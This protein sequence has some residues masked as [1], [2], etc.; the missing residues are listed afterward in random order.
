MNSATFLEMHDRCARMP[1]LSQSWE[2]RL[3]SPMAALY[4]A[5]EAGLSYDGHEDAGQFSGDTL[6]GLAVD[7]GLDTTQADLFGLANHLSAMADLITWLM[8]K[9]GP[10]HRPEN[11]KVGKEPWESSVFLNEAGT[12]LKRIV[13][14][15]HWSDEREISE[16]HSW[17]SVGECAAYG[18]PMDQTILLIGSNRSGRRHG[19]FS[20][21]WTHPVSKQLRMRK[22]NGTGFD[23]S[24]S[25]VFREEWEGSRDGWLDT[26]TDDGILEDAI[27]HVE[28]DVHPESKKIVKLAEKKLAQI[29]E[30]MECPPPSPSQCDGISPCPYR[31]ACWS[32]QT[33]SIQLGY[34][35]IGDTHP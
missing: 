1:F 8:T 3:L 32:F 28:V 23:G 14:V 35:R 16:S 26:M 18:M 6:M 15:D 24:W 21:A 9:D 29:R 7:R 31:S 4:Q 33:P 30:T 5:I 12:R 2:R 10:W 13:L 25:P 20:K 34:L 22:R 27:F 11:T 19:P 17:R